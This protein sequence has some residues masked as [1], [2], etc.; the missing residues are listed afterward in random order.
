MDRRSIIWHVQRVE[1]DQRCQLV[2]QAGCDALG[3]GVG[4]AAMHNAMPH[5]HKPARPEMRIGECQQFIEHG[6]ETLRAAFRPAP[7]GQ[8]RTGG[9]VRTK[10]RRRVQVFH[11]AARRFGKVL[12]GIE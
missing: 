9:V 1:R 6:G 2:Q 3:R 4:Y 5:G 8:Y 12:G 10:M 11:L 7:L